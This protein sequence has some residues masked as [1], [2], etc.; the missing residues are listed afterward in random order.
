MH[1]L[2]VVEQTHGLDGLAQPLVIERLL[3][4]NVKRRALCT[5]PGDNSQP[6]YGQ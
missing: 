3:E 2:H 1:V 4:R 6:N 5:A